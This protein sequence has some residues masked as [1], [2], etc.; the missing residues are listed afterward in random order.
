MVPPSQ[1]L[2]QVPASVP[3]EE[4]EAYAAV[5]AAGAVMVMPTAATSTKKLRARSLIGP[6][7]VLGQRALRRYPRAERYTRERLVFRPEGE[8][9][10]QP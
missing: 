10:R 3:H 9:K 1:C 2:A 6:P 4:F 8:S 7:G 5:P